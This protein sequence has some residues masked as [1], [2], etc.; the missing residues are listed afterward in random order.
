MLASL[1]I[2][3]LASLGCLL[4]SDIASFL[5]F[6]MLQAAII[7]GYAVSSAAIA[8]TSARDRA[9]S[10]MGYVASFWALAPMLAPILGGVLDEAFGW[11]ASFWVLLALGALACALAWAD[12]GETNTRRTTSMA[13]QMRRYPDLLRARIF[14]GYALCRA[15]STGTF[16][17]FLGGAPLAAVQSFGIGS[18]TLGLYMGLMSAGF[19]VGN[20]VSGRYAERAGLA[21]MM[22]AGR[23]TASAGLAAGLALLL[24]GQVHAAVL[25]GAC[26]FAG[27]GNGLTLPSAN[28]GAMAVRPELAGSAAGVNGALALACGAL[29]SGLTGALLTPAHAAPTL[30]GVMLAASLLALWAALAVRRMDRRAAA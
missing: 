11:R 24:A 28:A 12:F 16:Y 19:L 2:F 29:V 23:L 1:A 30:L 14:W 15:F 13:A 5:A 25:F 4:A 27:L 21:A 18:G 22:I 7:S 3:A 10:R 9:A 20:I 6:R 17:A 26:V 8:D